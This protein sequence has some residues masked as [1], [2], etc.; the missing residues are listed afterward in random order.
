M[1]DLGE[2]QGTGFPGKPGKCSLVLGA[3]G[4]RLNSN[5]QIDGTSVKNIA[6]AVMNAFSGQFTGTGTF[7][8]L[9]NTLATDNAANNATLT[10]IRKLH[11]NDRIVNK[12]TGVLT[13]FDDDGTTPLVQIQLKNGDGVNNYKNVLEWREL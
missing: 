4:I 6:A 3:S 13:I 7:G 2:F 9:L 10:L 8:A 11:K 1:A 5:L 12:A